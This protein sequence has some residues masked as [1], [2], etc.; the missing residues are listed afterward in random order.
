MKELCFIGGDMRQVRVINKML[1]K[2]YRVT[3]WGFENLPDGE[4]SG[5]VAVPE[6]MNEAIKSADVVILPLPYTTGREMINAPFSK[7]EIHMGDVLRNM[8]EKGIL[9]LGKADEGISAVAKLYGAYTIDYLEREE[10]GILNAIPTAEGAIEIAM[11][12]M[13]ITLCGSKCLILGN[14]KIG[15]ILGN[16]LM[17]I[18]AKVTVCVR[19]YKDAAEARSRGEESIFFRD[20]EERIGDYD[21]IFN[22]VPSCVVGYKVLKKVKQESL[23]IDLAS[24]PGGVDFETAA[25]LEKKVIHALS[26]PGKVAPYTAGDFISET[27]LNILEELGV[28]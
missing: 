23:I 27:I 11:H 5:G 18:G 17:G 13:P 25:Q 12:E 20:L 15:K 2:G 8:S 28:R 22:T 10:L 26:L 9:L 21:V 7:E 1:D 3:A 6:N 19:K 4:L 16:M 14:G 24:K